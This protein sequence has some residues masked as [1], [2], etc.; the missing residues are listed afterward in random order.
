MAIWHCALLA[1]DS[2]IYPVPC[3]S[4]IISVASAGISWLVLHFVT[5]IVLDVIDAVFVCFAYDKECCMYSQPKVH[6]VFKQI[7]CCGGPSPEAS[8]NTGNYDPTLFLGRMGDPYLPQ[9]T[10]GRTAGLDSLYGSVSSSG[11]ATGGNTVEYW[12]AVN[13]QYSSHR[14]PLGPSPLFY[15]PSFNAD[16]TRLAQEVARG[17]QYGQ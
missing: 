16:Q 8:S 11:G 9:V 17:M 1:L 6:E 3:S 10:S 12:Q 4:Q 5:S 2:N 15:S 14:Q 13:H 7:P